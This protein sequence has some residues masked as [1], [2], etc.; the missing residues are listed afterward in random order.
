MIDK[1]VG[2]QVRK[3]VKSLVT[4]GPERNYEKDCKI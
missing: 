4:M 3:G 1:L 2:I